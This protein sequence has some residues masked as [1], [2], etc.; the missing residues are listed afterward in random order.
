MDVAQQKCNIFS[1]DRDTN[2]YIIVKEKEKNVIYPKYLVDFNWK[3]FQPRVKSIEKLI[4][5]KWMNRQK[6]NLSFHRRKKNVKTKKTLFFL[7]F[8][9]ICDFSCAQ[10]N[11][12]LFCMCFKERTG[13]VHD[14][15][16][17]RPHV[18]YVWRDALLI[19]R[20]KISST[21]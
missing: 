16:S 12:T 5:R 9:Y 21:C 15:L 17:L 8:N 11:D 3:L 6:W 13:E 20:C 19:R 18:S 4:R 2:S 14:Q 10:G 7:R 1:R